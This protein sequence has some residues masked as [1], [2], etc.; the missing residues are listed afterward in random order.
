VSNHIHPKASTQG[1]AEYFKQRN[2][3]H[4]L[5]SHSILKKDFNL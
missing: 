5:E 1:N 4:F 2:E 3:A